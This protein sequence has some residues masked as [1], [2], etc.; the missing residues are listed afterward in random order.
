MIMMGLILIYFF[1]YKQPMEIPRVSRYQCWPPMIWLVLTTSRPGLHRCWTI[2]TSLQL[3][4]S[5]LLLHP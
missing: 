3:S 4:G 2:S 5:T 1:Y